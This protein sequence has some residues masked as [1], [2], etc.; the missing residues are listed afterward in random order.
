MSVREW[1]WKD[2][3]IV[4]R[5][6]KQYQTHRELTP[7]VMEYMAAT[8]YALKKPPYNRIG[9]PWDHSTQFY[10][11]GLEA[12]R[13]LEIKGLDWWYKDSTFWFTH[14]EHKVLVYL[15]MK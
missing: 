9:H 2:R 12:I 8:Y 3:V 15:M 6:G 14:E 4:E 7:E 1:I 11:K 5:W 10:A 13:T